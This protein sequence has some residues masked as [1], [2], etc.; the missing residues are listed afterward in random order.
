MQSFGSYG[1]G[2]GSYGSYGA[3][4]VGAPT[5]AA[6]G[7]PQEPDLAPSVIQP[8]ESGS[9][10][11][12]TE[13]V[14]QPYMPPVILLP[15]WL[16]HYSEITQYPQQ[17]W[18]TIINVVNVSKEVPVN[19]IGEY[20]VRLTATNPGSTAASYVDFGMSIVDY[21]Q[22]TV[23]LRLSHISASKLTAS[24][25]A[26]IQHAVSNALSLSADQ[27]TPPAA[28]VSQGRR[29][30]TAA[31]DLVVTFAITKLNGVAAAQS[32]ASSMVTLV[33]SG[34]LDGALQKAGALRTARSSGGK[35]H[36]TLT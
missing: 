12:S 30:L 11:N 3:P 2:F 26:I 33:S 6:G 25:Q 14:S 17:A 27:I 5:T 31:S 36:T 34:H 28:E 7:L 9:T 10:D 32:V 8:N 18:Y 16:A 22:C 35:I 13:P 19:A 1:E 24:Q 15:S 20:T 21:Y 4:V 23:T 29:R